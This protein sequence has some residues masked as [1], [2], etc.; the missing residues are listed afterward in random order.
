M[1]KLNNERKPIKQIDRERKTVTKVYDERKPIR[2]PDRYRNV[3]AKV[4]NERKSE[5]IW[6][7]KK[8]IK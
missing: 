4:N 2:L 1:T 7:I 6:K 5:V 3:V 8:K